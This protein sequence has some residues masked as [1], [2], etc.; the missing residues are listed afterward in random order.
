MNSL[1]RFAQMMPLLRQLAGGMGGM[2][3]L[4]K[5]FEE[6]AAS[7]SRTTVVGQAGGGLVRVTASAERVIKSVDIDASLLRPEG[8]AVLEELVRAATND[9]LA[10][11]AEVEKRTYEAATTKL[12]ADLPSMMSGL[13][14]ALGKK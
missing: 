7:V 4:A 8:K 11:G 5:P 1:G 6:A 12:Q 14:G 9:A 13:M 10:S 3:G 2:G